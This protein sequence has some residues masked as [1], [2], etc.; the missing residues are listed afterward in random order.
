MTKNTNPAVITLP[1]GTKVYSK[2]HSTLMKILSVILFF[3]RSFMDGYWTTVF[4]RVYSPTKVSLLRH[5]ERFAYHYHRIIEHEHIHAQDW[6]KLPILFDIS[7][8]LLPLPLGLAWC[9]W[10]WERR[11]YLPEIL[12]ITDDEKREARINKIADNLGDWDY[13]LTYPKPWMRKWFQ[14]QYKKHNS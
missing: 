1:D 11:A 13:F 12:R 4:G 14:E 6:Q 2:K 9:R 7:Y 5:P 3:N 10:Y 8:I